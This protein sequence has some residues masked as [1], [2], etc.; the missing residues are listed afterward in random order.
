MAKD[1]N[2]SECSEKIKCGSVGI[3]PTDTVV[4][5]GCRFDSVEGITRIRGIK[6][7]KDTSPLAVLISSAEQLET[8]KVRKSRIF[9]KLAEKLWPGPLTIVATAE[10]G[11]PCSGKGNSLGIR[12]P[13]SDL[14]RTMIEE[15][16]VPIA[17]TS[18][19]LHG[20]PAPKLI[21]DVD[22]EIVDA[23]DCKIELPIK[24][25]GVPSTVIVIVAGEIK[26]IRVGGVEEVEILA[27][28]SEED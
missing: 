2:L 1:F 20:R 21:E 13:D 9:N 15:A 5:L 4:G 10:E 28:L 25:L 6:G 24:S 8:L 14:L 3:F 23:V 16:G 18:A 17:A 19:N 12:M 27:A 22:S 7:I 11:Y 26:V